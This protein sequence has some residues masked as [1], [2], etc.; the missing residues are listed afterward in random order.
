MKA[1]KD[2]ESYVAEIPK[3]LSDIVAYAAEQNASA[4]LADEKAKE[5]V[6]LCKSV[7]DKKA[8]LVAAQT[9]LDDVRRAFTAFQKLVE[10]S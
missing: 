5:Y 4:N 8:E 3:C 9:E 10:R 7:V 1:L 6:S 2:L